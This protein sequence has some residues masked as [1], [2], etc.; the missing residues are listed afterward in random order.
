MHLFRTISK[1]LVC[2]LTALVPL[3]GFP[4]TACGCAA[5][6]KPA[7]DSHWASDQSPTCCCRRQA[8]RGVEP[9][10]A[11]HSCCR[12]A[13]PDVKRT[14]C[15]CSVG[16]QCKKGDS[17]PRPKQLPLENRG[18]CCDQAAVPLVIFCLECGD[19]QTMESEGRKAVSLSA[20]DRCVLLCRFLL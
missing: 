7:A 17:S 14:C 15:S 16:C 11:L 6:A 4:S 1:T 18:R 12:P 5:P 13:A 2:L 8:S 3:Q 19:P 9:P 10:T 20:A